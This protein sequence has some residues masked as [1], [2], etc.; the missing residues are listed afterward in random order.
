MSD[1]PDPLVP[2]DIDLQDVPF[3]IASF[4]ELAMQELGMDRETADR[5]VRAAA[6]RAGIPSDEVGHG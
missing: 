1:L 2:A 5:E 6:E 4:V 3:P